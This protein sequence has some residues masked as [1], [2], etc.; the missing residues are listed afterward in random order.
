MSPYKIMN[1]VICDYVMIQDVPTFEPLE[2][3]RMDAKKPHRPTDPEDIVD[4]HN[5]PGNR[6]HTYSLHDNQ[7]LS[8]IL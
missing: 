2:D 3:Y 1:F 7:D 4:L 8:L 6:G 5:F